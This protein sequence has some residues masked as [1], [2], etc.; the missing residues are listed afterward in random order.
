MTGEQA[1]AAM[2]DPFSF[3]MGAAEVGG[4]A[5]IG[6]ALADL[7]DE[8]DDIVVV[9]PD[10]AVTPVGGAFA[11]R[12]PDRLFDLGIA[13]NNAVSVAA[14][15]AASGYVPYV[16]MMGAFASLKCA[17]QIRTD[18]AYNALR[19]RVLAAWSGLAMGYFGTSHHAVEEIGLAR[20]IPGLTVVAPSDDASARALLRST[21]DHPGPVLFRLGDGE[22]SDVHRSEPHVPRGAMVAVRAGGDATVIATGRGVQAAAEAADRLAEEGIRVE[23]LDALYLKPLDE[24]A[25]VEAACRTGRILTV[26]E[27]NV[28]GG[29]GTAVAEVLARHGVVAH[30]AL[31]GLPDERLVAGL[32]AQLYERYGLTPAGVEQRLRRL[33]VG[34][35]RRAT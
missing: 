15:M 32:P 6:R 27:H 22:E 16:I 4:G 7:A 2:A 23:V 5:A 30:L 9:T 19:V 28:V 1:A 24:E 18:L 34:P 8:R 25:I 33:V 17:E 21:V 10:M 13:E 31:Q 14:G 11:A 35:R 26:E 3:N 29:L 12:H 20:S